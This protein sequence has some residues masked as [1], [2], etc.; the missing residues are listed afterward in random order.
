MET[1]NKTGKKQTK[2]KK[3][4]ES[5]FISFFRNEVVRFV[6]GS[7]FAILAVFTLVSFILS[8]HVGGRPESAFG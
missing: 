6:A 5:P 3:K 1:K 2:K 4:Q 7:I 8:F